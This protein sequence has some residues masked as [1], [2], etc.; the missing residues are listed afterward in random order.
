MFVAI[1]NKFIESIGTLVGALFLLLPSSPFQNIP[2]LDGTW[3]SYI[4]YFIP[5]G[6]ILAHTALYI[7]AVGAYYLIRIALRWAKAIE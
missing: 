2:S 3:I 6:T 4:N 1:I 7:T 5:V